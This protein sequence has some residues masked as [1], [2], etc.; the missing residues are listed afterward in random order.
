MLHS[1][2]IACQGGGSHTAFTAGVLKR[3]LREKENRFHIA[4]LSGT[5]GGAIC[6]AVA[7]YGLLL[8][9][10]NKAVELLDNFWQDTMAASL[11]DLLL[12]TSIVWTSRLRSFVP[13][14]EINPSLVPLWTQE[15]L[16]KMIEK[17]IDFSHIKTLFNQSSPH[18]L[19][20]AVNL[21]TGAFKV[22]KNTEVTAQ[23][24]LASAAVPTL[25]SAV[26]IGEDLYWDGL[27][28]HNP[29]LEGLTD[30]KPDEIWVIQINPLSRFSEPKS[31]D[32]IID[33]RNELSANLSLEQE[34]YFI[35][36]IN[37]LLKNNLIADTAKYKHIQIRRIKMCRDLD[38][39]SK[40]ERSPAFIKG[41]MSYGENEA[42]KFLT[43]LSL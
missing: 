43:N 33:R 13:I 40:L 6:A 23:S 24:L 21:L 15:L 37:E 2:A 41:M 34:L 27:F 30:I 38:Y 29:P 32:E 26:K 11:W 35:E 5:S 39:A 25:F 3:I 17:Q 19:I 12:N 20:G 31:I 42:E 9:D 1:I 16:Q 22:F 36:K 10:K 14:P 7:W 18:L 28:S 8:N 4:A